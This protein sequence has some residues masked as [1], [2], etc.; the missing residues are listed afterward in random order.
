MIMIFFLYYLICSQVDRS[1]VFQEITFEKDCDEDW[2]EWLISET[3]D[4]VRDEDYK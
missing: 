3:A 1:S 2:I 4:A